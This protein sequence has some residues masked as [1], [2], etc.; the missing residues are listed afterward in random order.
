MFHNWDF[1]DCSV[2]KVA[3]R[4]THYSTNQEQK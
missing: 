2:Y 3:L 1:I 4:Q